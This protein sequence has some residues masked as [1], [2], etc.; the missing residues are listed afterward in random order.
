MKTLKQPLTTDTQALSY[1]GIIIRTFEPLHFMNLSDQ[2]REA[3]LRSYRKG[4]RLHSE[5]SHRKHYQK[6]PLKD[7]DKN[8]SIN[9]KTKYPMETHFFNQIA[10]LAIQ[11]KLHLVITQEANSQL[12][13]SV[14]LENEQCSDPAKLLLPPLVLRGTAEELD[15]GFFQSITQP[16][17]ETSSLLVNM[18]QYIEAQKQAQRQSAM[19]KEKAEKQQ[20]KYDEAMKKVADLEAQGKYREAWSKLPPPDEFPNYA[21]K[22][23]K[24]R[25]ELSTHFAP[26]LFEE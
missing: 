9:L 17:E 16:L 12:V 6:S 20:K 19:E 7:K 3:S 4:K 1:I 5:L 18:E 22:I 25:S 14:L 26:T 2:D 23:R 13:V 8:R 24:K 21:D 10:Q 15:A 11:G